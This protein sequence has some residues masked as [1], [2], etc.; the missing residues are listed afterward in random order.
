MDKNIVFFGESGLTSTSANHVAN[1]AK[2]YAKKQ[3]SELNAVCFYNTQIGLIGTDV[4]NT[5]SIGISEE[6]LLEIPAKL[7]EVTKAKSLIAWLREAIKARDAMFEAA[8]KKDIEEWYKE[9]GLELWNAPSRPTQFTK[10]DIIAT[11]NI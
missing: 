10:D 2:E 3:E 1:L 9:R 7:E 8:N 6:Q 11:L 5:V 4:K